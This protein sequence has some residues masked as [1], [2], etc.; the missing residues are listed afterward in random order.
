MVAAKARRGGLPLPPAAWR[1]ARRLA[2]FDQ[3]VTAPLHGFRDAAHYY[4][5]ADCRPW[6]ARVRVPTL[7]VQALDDPFVPREAA[8]GL[9]R[10]LEEGAVRLELLPRGGHVGFVAGSPWRPRYWLEERLPAFL[11]PR[12]EG[13]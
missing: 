4:A 8:E 3:R 2:D 5:A 13:P 1:G 10:W 9:G 11:A 12:L 7:L 6:L